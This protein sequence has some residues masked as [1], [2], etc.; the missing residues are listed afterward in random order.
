MKEPKLLWN[1]EILG[2]GEG[3]LVKV[4]SVCLERRGHNEEG[5][6]TEV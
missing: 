5:N 2:P 3:C 4:D 1:V 6:S